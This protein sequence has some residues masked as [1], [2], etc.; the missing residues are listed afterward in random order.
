MTVEGFSTLE[1]YKMLSLIK[2]ML[3]AVTD[4]SLGHFLWMNIPENLGKSK[5]HAKNPAIFNYH[6]KPISG[7][8]SPE[9]NLPF[10]N[11]P[12]NKVL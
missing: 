7:A 5:I 9:I 4:I 6:S 10:T 12:G 8:K 11:V 1:M 3:R 2:K